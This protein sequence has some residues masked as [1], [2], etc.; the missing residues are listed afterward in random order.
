MFGLEKY[1]YIFGYPR[2]GFH[3]WRIPILDIALLDTL[4]TILIGIVIW[5]FYDKTHKVYS[6]LIIIIICVF[7]LGELLHVLF[8]IR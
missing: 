3:K 2:E 1:K 8:G 7:A 6:E 4:G 5:W